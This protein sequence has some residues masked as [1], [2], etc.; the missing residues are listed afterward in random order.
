MRQ[1]WVGLLFCSQSIVFWFRWFVSGSRLLKSSKVEVPNCGSREQQE[2]RVVRVVQ[3]QVM[4]QRVVRRVAFRGR[5][6]DGNEGT[7]KV[8]LG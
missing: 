1:E 4:E 2:T 8:V 7:R 3:A 5:V 6:K